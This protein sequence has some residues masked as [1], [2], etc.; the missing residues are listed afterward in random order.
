MID[1]DKT[2]YKTNCEAFILTRQIQLDCGW[3]RTEVITGT[4]SLVEIDRIIAEQVKNIRIKIQASKQNKST[5]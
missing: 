4:P 1:R 2:R 5:S 3:G